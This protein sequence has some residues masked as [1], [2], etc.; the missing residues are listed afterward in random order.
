METRALEQKAKEIRR[1]IVAMIYHAKSGHPG[2]SLSCTDILTV[3]YHEVMNLALD[4]KGNRI[5]KCILSKGHAAPAYYATLSSVGFIPKEDLLTLRKADSYLEG[6][7]SNKIP[8]VDSSSGSLGQG[9]SIANGMALSKKISQ[10]EGYVY[11]VLGDGELEE[12]QIWEALMSANKYELSQ[13][14]VFIDHNGLQI[15]GTVESV[16][17]L[18]QLSEKLESF[19][20]N[21][22]TIDGHQ[23]EAI[24]QS[25]ENA[26]KSRKPNCIIANTIK[27]KG[28]S[29]MENK[30]EW[31]G[32]SITL[33]EYEIA[34]KELA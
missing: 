23:V 32:K 10:Q 14:I 7:P 26:K 34:M 18:E 25:V 20:M 19:G 1:D 24:L 2:G 30:V 16:K 21:V 22:Q 12:G 6:H 15:D 8:G 3:L 9:L 33:E 17:K 31:H 4:E 13:L 27:G 5:D 29:F 28:I 11:C